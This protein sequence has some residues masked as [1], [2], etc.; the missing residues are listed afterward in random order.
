MPPTGGETCRRNA[1][2]TYQ[3]QAWVCQNK[4]FGIAF[5]SSTEFKLRLITFP[6]PAAG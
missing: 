2:I 1:E 6:F 4:S 3:L 5:D